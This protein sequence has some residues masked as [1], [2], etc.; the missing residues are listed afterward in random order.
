L[1][2]D[3]LDVAHLGGLSLGLE[4]RFDLGLFRGSDGKFVAGLLVQVKAMAKVM[5]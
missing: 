2:S 4:L 3:C 5:T 1:S